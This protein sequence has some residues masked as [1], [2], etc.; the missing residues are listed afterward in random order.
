MKKPKVHD[1]AK[2]SGKTMINR[3]K[4]LIKKESNIRAAHKK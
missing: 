2:A 1:Y 4:E 3:A